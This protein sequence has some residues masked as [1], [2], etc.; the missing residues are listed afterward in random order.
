M[1]VAYGYGLIQFAAGIYV[2]VLC[3]L[4]MFAVLFHCCYDWGETLLSRV[5]YCPTKLA[6]WPVKPRG[7]RMYD[8]DTA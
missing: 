1:T 8:V 3:S 2:G 4:Y 7:N 5:Q 6:C